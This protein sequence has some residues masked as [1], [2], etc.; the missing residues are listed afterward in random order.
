MTSPR[1]DPISAPLRVALCPIHF[2]PA[3]H[4][5]LADGVPFIPLNEPVFSR[6]FEGDRLL[7]LLDPQTEEAE[8][9]L[10][11]LRYAVRSVY[12]RHFTDRIAEILKACA[13]WGVQLVVFPEF[14]IPG[15]CLLPLA[16]TARGMT[17]VFGSHTVTSSLLRDVSIYKL[18][19]WSAV[20]EGD[21]V[22]P[23]LMPEGQWRLGARYRPRE[24]IFWTEQD[25][26]I[27][28]PTGHRM[29][30]TSGRPIEGEKP[31][32]SGYGFQTALGKANLLVV[33]RFFMPGEIVKVDIGR[34]KVLGFDPGTPA[35]HASLRFTV[36]CSEPLAEH[37]DT[38][39]LSQNLDGPSH[40]YRVP[41]TE[42]NADRIVIA[43]L[44]PIS[45]AAPRP[46]LKATLIPHIPLSGLD[47]LWRR[48]ARLGEDTAAVRQC[49]DDHQAQIR[50][51]QNILMMH[52]TT[53]FAGHEIGAVLRR[54]RK[55]LRQILD[56]HQVNTLA[57]MRQALGAFLSLPSTCPT[58]A[59][60]EL[61]LAR[62]VQ[63]DLRAHVADWPADALLKRHEAMMGF[64]LDWFE[65]DVEPHLL[66]QQHEALVA[67]A[68]ERGETWPGSTLPADSNRVRLDVKI[69]DLAKQAPQVLADAR[70]A[71]RSS[72]RP[73]WPGS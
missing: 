44:D 25:E 55:R 12:L 29:M 28:L 70:C 3:T 51:W 7:G 46:I 11:A 50:Q 40:S 73:G 53:D 38:A 56:P 32:P 27:V 15:E 71:S 18:E 37:G 60:L 34:W 24:T 47:A 35:R 30:V 33:P 1:P 13:A 14:A 42:S 62:A 43:D 20:E 66:L 49:I 52:A 41:F 31:S 36:T 26:P 5:K 48:V 61:G 65:C 64:N 54:C 59:D 39:V 23:V 16:S 21:T 69:Q 58:S 22:A 68:N 67:R 63:Q 4:F 72:G 6:D 8:T 45:G 17:V 2:H 9:S 10:E 57:E 19:G